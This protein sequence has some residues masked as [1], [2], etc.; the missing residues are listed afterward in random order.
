MSE[1]DVQIEVFAKVAKGKST[2]A[3]LIKNALAAQGIL[4]VEIEDDDIPPQGS[5]IGAFTD[6]NLKRKYATFRESKIVIKTV[7]VSRTGKTS[8]DDKE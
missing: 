4:N 1:P 5:R 3:L 8:G 2:I 6:A 7:Q